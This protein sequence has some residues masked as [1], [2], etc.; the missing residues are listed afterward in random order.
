MTYSTYNFCYDEEKKRKENYFNNIAR[1]THIH[2]PLIA[3]VEIYKLALPT[4]AK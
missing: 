2:S 3:S 4:K 1:N